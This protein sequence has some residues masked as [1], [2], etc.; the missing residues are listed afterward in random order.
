MLLNTLLKKVAKY[1][2]DHPDHYSIRTLQNAA[3]AADRSLDMFIMS[4]HKDE[5]M[6]L[7]SL[8][9]NAFPKKL[10]SDPLVVTQNI[11]GAW[12][13]DP[14]FKMPKGWNPRDIDGGGYLG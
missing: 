7:R 6:G 1:L 14:V 5:I 3:H 13:V 2:Q 12:R 8:V 9:R 4:L 11:H 10:R